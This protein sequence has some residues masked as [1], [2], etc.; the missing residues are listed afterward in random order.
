MDI[1]NVNP[2]GDGVSWQSWLPQ[3]TQDGGEDRATGV[4]QDGTGQG[5]EA[6]ADN[7]NASESETVKPRHWY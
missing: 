7:G 6:A 5:N 2:V 1:A 4:H 3:Q